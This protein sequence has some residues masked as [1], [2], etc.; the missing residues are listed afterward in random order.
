MKQR[1]V[2][3]SQHQWIDLLKNYYH[4]ILYHLVKKNIVKNTLRHETVGTSNLS[5]LFV[6]ERHLSLDIESLSNQM[7]LL[8]IYQI[9]GVS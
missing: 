7:I 8:D 1:D 9:L 6:L 2:D 5:L 4:S 3:L